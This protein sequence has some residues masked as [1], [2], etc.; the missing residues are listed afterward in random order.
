MIL[1]S[2]RTW[3]I[4]IALLF[5]C[6]LLITH[7]SYHNTSVI[8]SL[9]TMQQH[10]DYKVF[11]NSQWVIVIIAFVFLSN[12][13]TT[14]KKYQNIFS[15]SVLSSFPAINQKTGLSDD[16]TTK[17][18]RPK[19]WRKFSH[20]LRK[21]LSRRSRFVGTAQQSEKVSS[22]SL[23]S[24]NWVLERVGT[25]WKVKRVS[26]GFSL[27]S[28]W[29]FRSVFIS[30]YLKNCENTKEARV[31][32]VRKILIL[33]ACASDDI[34]SEFSMCKSSLSLSRILKIQSRREK[35]GKRGKFFVIC[36]KYLK[37]PEK[38]GKFSLKSEVKNKRKEKKAN[39]LVKVW[40]CCIISFPRENG[41]E[42]SITSHTN[43]SHH[44]S[45]SYT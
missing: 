45:K 24:L 14:L 20:F 4:Q 10:D 40:K 13:Q 19:K 2:G 43:A 11:T 6:D 23:L 25:E 12:F 31:K 9:I 38:S 41:A 37:I 5:V 42:S 8:F 15:L 16:T 44:L 27:F 18:K 29:F 3:D 32:R 22:F 36:E 34:Y 33:R 30:R 35:E 1:C 39:G 17:K 21:S 26:A 28:S 7:N